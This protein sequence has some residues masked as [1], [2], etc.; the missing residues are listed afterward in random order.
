MYGKIRERME[1][2]RE[3]LAE[4]MRITRK[5]MILFEICKDVIKVHGIISGLIKYD[6]H[7]SLSTQ[8][9]QKR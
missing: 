2:H 4:R 3:Q 9:L 8:D 6:K 5:Q 7:S 1:L